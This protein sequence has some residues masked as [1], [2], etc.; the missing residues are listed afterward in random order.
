MAIG[1]DLQVAVNGD[2]RHT[3]GTA[4]YTVLELHR[5]LQDLADDAAASTSGNDLV[6]IASGTPSERVTDSI[7]NLLGNYNIDDTLSE[8]LYGGS[9]SQDSGNTVYSG[10]RV[11]GA[12][13]DTDTQLTVV[14]DHAFYDSATAPFWGD[15][16]TG[17]W[18]GNA[19]AG[20]LMRIL[21]KTRESGYDIDGQRVR[22]QA[23]HYEATQGDTYDFFNVQLG[24]GEA[25]AAISTTPDPQ[26]DTAKATVTA[27]THITNSGGTA[28]APTGGYQQIDIN[29]GNGNQPY[30]SKWTFG[31]DTSGDGLKGMYEY[32]K[33]LTNT[34]T[35]KTCDGI[36]GDLFLGITHEWDYDNDT[37]AFNER[38][39]IVWGTEITYDTLAGGTF[40]EGYYVT[41]GAS[42]AA[43][44]IGY[45]NGTVQMTVALEDTS[46]TL[47][48]NDVI[49]EYNP[50]TGVAT[51]VTAAINVTIV[52]NDKDGG[53]A[54]LLADDTTGDTMWVQLISGLAPSNNQ[55]VRSQ[56]GGSGA[57]C[58]V[59][60]A[61]TSRT[62]PKIFLG[63]YTGS[64]IGA[65]GIGIDDG[66]LSFPDT[67]QDLDGDT[68][69]APNNVTFTVGGLISSE[70]RVLVGTKDLTPADDFDKDQL[71]LNT[72]L[73]SAGQTSI[74]CTTAIPADTP[75]SGTVRVELDVGTYRRV[76]YTSWTGSTFTTASTDWTDPDDAT[77]GNNIFISYIDK[78][79]ASTSEAFTTVYNADRSLWVRVRDGGATPIKTFES[80]ATLGSGGGTITAIRTS[81]A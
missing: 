43:G 33:D 68:N 30:Y 25:V 55:E 44:K 49:T 46:I 63:S 8:Y 7:I 31:A 80:Q 26:N 16:S 50:S 38:E 69:S 45:D 36:N 52:D 77:A 64:L 61:P 47:L 14:Q 18:N 1:D 27:Y 15:Q 58:L 23:R 60:L 53:E 35:S 5:W 28:N 17:G 51:G 21:I 81:D 48:N 41:I 79:A 40:T 6:D 32:L 62:V 20:I 74:V 72:T 39:K 9:I 73:N 59:N 34:G 4:H 10:L 13:N 71:S 3:S 37:G 76:A 19:A 75:S 67:V 42:G 12:V 11:L 65:F 70:D 24:T 54:I 56:N 66:D 2:I 78:T 29:D 22:V 57:Y